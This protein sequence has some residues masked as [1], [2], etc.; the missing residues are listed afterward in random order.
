M[1]QFLRHLRLLPLLLLLALVSACRTPSS[2]PA[3]NLAE[4][5]WRVRQGQAVWR[6]GMSEPELAGELLLATHADGRTWLEFTKTPLTL[7]Q[8]RTDA[9]GW[10]AQFPT[11][12]RAFS[13]RNAAPRTIGWLHLAS[14]L[15]GRPPP[16][17]WSFAV[18]P[19]D[20][21]RLENA[22]TGEVIDGFF[23]P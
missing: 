4:P 15:E 23:A 16:D 9:H 8:G 14:C 11:R 3:L 17:G 21:W 22:A 18:K 6:A 2:W 13:G 7:V 1:N 19:G 20:A 12:G 10:R 5:G